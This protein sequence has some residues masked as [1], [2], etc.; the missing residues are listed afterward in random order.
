[1]KQQRIMMLLR[2]LFL[3]AVLPQRYPLFTTAQKS[4]TKT[5]K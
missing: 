2:L 4:K 3:F 5:N 1:M